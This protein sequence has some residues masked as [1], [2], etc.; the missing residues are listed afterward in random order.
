ML[1]YEK[2]HKDKGQKEWGKGNA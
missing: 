2:A 1:K